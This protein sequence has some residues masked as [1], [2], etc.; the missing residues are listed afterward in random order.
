MPKESTNLMRKK[1][2]ECVLS[3][4]MTFH[5]E[6]FTYLKLKQENFNINKGKN[7]EKI[8]ESLDSMSLSKTKQEF[9]NILIHE[10]RHILFLHHNL[11]SI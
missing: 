11:E 9:L 10:N 7:S 2:I 4:D 6:Q 3:T 5:T 1:I 8:V